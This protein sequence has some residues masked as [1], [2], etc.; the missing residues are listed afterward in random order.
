MVTLSSLLFELL[1][2]S[3][4]SDWLIASHSE[5]GKR[6]SRRLV[7]DGLHANTS[8]ILLVINWIARFLHGRF[9]NLLQL[10]M[11]CL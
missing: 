1:I 3:R 9:P 6:P 11:Y 4:M 7:S 8:L 10:F 2:M 5:S